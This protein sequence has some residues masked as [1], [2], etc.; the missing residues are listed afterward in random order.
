MSDHGIKNRSL[1]HENFV[2]QMDLE[3]N[4]W[5]IQH[6]QC[7]SDNLWTLT[8]L[9]N[10][11][12]DLDFNLPGD[13]YKNASSSLKIDFDG[14]RISL[15][16]IDVI[17]L[18]T[19]K[20]ISRYYYSGGV[21]TSFRFL[22]L[23]FLYLYESRKTIILKEDLEDFF[24]Y[25]LLHD[26]EKYPPRK[27]IQVPAHGTIFGGIKLYEISAMMSAYGAECVVAPINR[28][29]ALEALNST[30]ISVMNMTLNDYSKG[31][32]FN[33][34]T[35]DVGKHYLDHCAN[36]FEDEYQAA[37]AMDLTLPKA[38]EY[39]EHLF[40]GVKSKDSLK[41][42]VSELVYPL[43]A[44]FSASDIKALP[45]RERLN[46]LSIEE[47]QKS[48][49]FLYNTFEKHFNETAEI[50]S[51]FRLDSTSNILEESGF[52]ERYDSQEFVRSVLFSIYIIKE[53]DRTEEIFRRY[54][55]ALASNG[56]YSKIECS[57]FII[58]CKK[59]VKRNAKR[60]SSAADTSSLLANI[61]EKE[62]ILYK[63]VRPSS[64]KLFS[65]F[66]ASFVKRVLC[67]GIVQIAGLTGWRSSEFG[68]NC[69]SI[70]ISKNEDILDNLYTPWRFHVR[71]EV[72]KT[73]GASK[74]E[75]EITLQTYIILFQLDRFEEPAGDTHKSILERWPL[76]VSVAQPWP[77][78][79]LNYCLFA[80]LADVEPSNS[81]ST[82]SS[83]GVGQATTASTNDAGRSRKSEMQQLISTMEELRQDLPIYTAV[84]AVFGNSFSATIRCW[85]DEYWENRGALLLDTLLNEEEKTFIRSV[86]G[87]LDKQSSRSITR[88]LLENMRYP[89][90]HSFRHIWAE[91][92]LCR[93]RG[94]VGRF[95]RANFKH[96]DESFFMAYLRDKETK[97][98]MQIAK[99]TVINRTVRS[100]ILS[101]ADENREYAGGFDRFLDKALRYTHV[102]SEEDVLK[103]A[104]TIAEDRVDD[105]QP[106]PWSFCLLR[107]STK[108]T[109]RCS[110]DGEPR[111]YLAEPKLCL[112]CINA[113]IDEGNYE[114]IVIYIK[115]DIKACLNENLP[116][117]FKIEPLRVVRSALRRV[118]ELQRK[119]SPGKYG[120]FIVHLEKA[121][122]V[123]DESIS[124]ELIEVSHD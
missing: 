6:G 1:M 76:G 109:A 46:Q 75:R 25:A 98:V 40:P 104:N 9:R 47:I 110:Q 52:P 102:V 80:K 28:S 103:L 31:G 22:K 30:C 79:V 73:G 105:I 86:N 64:K 58:L 99:R 39:L 18:I 87:K 92:V 116:A 14:E 27:R 11:C 107:Q 4:L 44:G 124:K 19:V 32:S 114:G 118:R 21:V 95:I 38:R 59:V 78:F 90:P 49:D 51:A 74:Q 71:W 66:P 5:G 69:K 50:V 72:P 101:L 56:D 68:F 117:F 16:P 91:A 83:R 36:I 70:D 60:L 85:L 84:S 112:S 24:S 13:V 10:R 34:L 42:A 48:I 37:R 122:A 57:E 33:F 8:G 115:N 55:S 62:S 106:N 54:K 17:K 67:A 3:L 65:S 89:T 113:S 100:Q 29:V 97:I 2:S 123:A 23:V 45:H 35:L 111:R 20:L 12:V 77:D 26:C 96:M 121:I 53:S 93:Y 108:K 61:F 7:F 120:D 15:S 82:T 81:E 43:L 94:D 41:A 88:R 119:A 63:H